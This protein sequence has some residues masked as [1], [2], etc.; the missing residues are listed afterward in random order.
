[1][2]CVKIPS[3]R[4]TGHTTTDELKKAYNL[5]LAENQ[6]HFFDTEILDLKNGKTVSRSSPLFKMKPFLGEDGLL[7]MKGR[8]QCSE[9]S[10]NE[11]HP[12]LLPKCHIS[13]L[14]CRREHKSLNHA[15]VAQMIT[16]LRNQFWIINLRFIAKKVKRECVVCSRHDA[17]LPHQ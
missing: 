3:A 6:R 12:I 7:R 17:R 15:G 4:N 16:S 1:M 14:L 2:K 11:K 13:M 8:L 5:I 10:F 9:L